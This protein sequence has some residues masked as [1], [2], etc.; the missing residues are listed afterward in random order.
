MRQKSATFCLLFAWLCA[1]G[2][3]SNLA[4]VFAWGSMFAGYARE[5]PV[6]AALAETFD[7]RKPCDIC[8][9]DTKSR[10]SEDAPTR[11]GSLTGEKL[12]LTC[13]VA[14]TT[15]FP[16]PL[17]PRWAFASDWIALARTEPVP[18]PPPR[19]V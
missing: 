2:A 18:V 19:V 12:F 1:N 8:V 11:A 5:L 16:A 3:I 4:Q 17:I 9:A 15:G 14:T 6:S 10:A 7:A 13:P